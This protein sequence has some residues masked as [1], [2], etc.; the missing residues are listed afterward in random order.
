MGRC[1]RRAIPSATVDADPVLHY[2]RAMKNVTSMLPEDAAQ[3]LRVRAAE[4]EHGVSNRLVEQIEGIWC[5]EGEYAVA[6]KRFLAGKASKY[7]MVG[8]PHA[9]LEQ[10]A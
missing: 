6:Q 7:W 4:N 9:E 1:D 3:G 10:V 2:I 8:R 5:R